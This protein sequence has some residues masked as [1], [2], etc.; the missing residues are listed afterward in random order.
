MNH[1]CLE[2]ALAVWHVHGTNVEIWYNGDHVIYHLMVHGWFD[3]KG[4]CECPAN[5]YRKLRTHYTFREI[6]CVFRNLS[7]E[8]L[9]IF[10]KQVTLTNLYNYLL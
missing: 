3:D 10:I 7:P 4:P 9:T 6:V 2:V 8:S 1:P 5:N